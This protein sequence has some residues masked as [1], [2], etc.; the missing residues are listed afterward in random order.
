MSYNFQFFVQI[1]RIDCFYVKK[2]LILIIITIPPSSFIFFYL[3][4]KLSFL[5]EISMMIGTTIL[6]TAAL[7][8]ADCNF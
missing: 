3:Y 8:E 5:T 2:M 7:K 4:H 6:A 1:F